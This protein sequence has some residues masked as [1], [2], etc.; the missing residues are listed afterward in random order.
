METFP[1]V[2]DWW[3]FNELGIKAFQ[4]CREVYP[5]DISVPE[6]SPLSSRVYAAGIN[7]RNML[8]AHCRL[9][10]EAAKKCPDNN[11]GVTHQ[12]LKF[13]TETGNW[14]EKTVAYFFTKFAFTPVYQF[15]KE[16]QFSFEFPFMANIQFEVTPDEFEKNDH[17]LKGGLG[18]QLYPA[19][20]LKMG[21]NHGH[22]YPGLPSAVHNF[23]FF[24]FGSTCEPGGTV[25]R[26]GPRWNSKA[27]K[28]FLD[29]AFALTKKVF[30]TETG[31]D[32]NVWED[33]DS[34]FN[35]NDAAQA[36]YLKELIGEIHHYVATTGREIQGIYVWSDLRR[37]MEWENGKAVLLGVIETI[38]DEFRR[39]IGYE[40]TEASAYLAEV[41]RAAEQEAAEAL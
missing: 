34:D 20:M 35:Q 12:W 7:T 28:E 19:P 40:D 41:Y 30:I 11:V 13:D 18:A 2:T 15:F 36:E 25:M 23:P 5:T 14:L 38:I 10:Q 26:F 21:L 1:E 32:A 24:T 22:T 4:Q 27:M 17:F 31:S 37:Q 6:G 9:Q 39:M 29:D 33:G 16:G 8:V 3:S